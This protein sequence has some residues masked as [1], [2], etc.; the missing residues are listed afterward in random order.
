MVLSQNVVT[1]CILL[2][3]HH[4]PCV[5]PVICPTFHPLSEGES[6]FVATLAS[7]RD[8]TVMHIYSSMKNQ[9]T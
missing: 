7:Q 6:L 2:N 5:V 3:D 4:L 1:A 8:A 9:P